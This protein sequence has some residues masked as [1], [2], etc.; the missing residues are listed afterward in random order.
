[1]IGWILL[2]VGYLVIFAQL[3]THDPPSKIFATRF[4]GR[5]EED[6]AFQGAEVKKLMRQFASGISD[7]S[8]WIL[9]PATFM[10]AGGVVLAGTAPSRK[11]KGSAPQARP[12]APR[13]G[14]PVAQSGSGGDTERPP[15][16]S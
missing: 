1:M 4:A 12:G 9:L 16:M 8:P 2:S 14:G 10:L 6:R 7:R 5:I 11:G 13:G 3:M 15:S